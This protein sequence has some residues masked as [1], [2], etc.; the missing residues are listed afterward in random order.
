MAH[1]LTKNIQEIARQ[2]KHEDY[3][4]EATILW[5]ESGKILRRLHKCDAKRHQ[6]DL[7]RSLHSYAVYLQRAGD[8]QGAEPIAK[9]AVF[10][11]RQLYN[12][13]SEL[14]R[15][16]ALAASLDNY[17]NTLRALGRFDDAQVAKQELIALRRKIFLAKSNHPAE[18][19][20]FARDFGEFLLQPLSDS[21]S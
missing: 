7:A 11:R 20:V 9:E 13:Q 1:T 19:P 14:R 6:S 4:V 15:S 21:D 5:E 16:S 17:A 10:L 8:S 2:L 12:T 3:C 18:L